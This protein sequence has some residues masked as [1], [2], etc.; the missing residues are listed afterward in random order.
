MENNSKTS[1]IAPTFATTADANETDYTIEFESHF[2]QYKFTLHCFKK[3]GY[4]KII[5][6]R[7]VGG[8]TDPLRPKMGGHTTKSVMHGSVTPDLWLSLIHISEPTRPY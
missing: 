4:G 7:I 2:V 1:Q 5:S 6:T 8:V 3:Q